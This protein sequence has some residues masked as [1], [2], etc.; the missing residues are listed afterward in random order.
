MI[1]ITEM[2]MYIIHPFI[3]SRAGCGCS[4]VS[5]LVFEKRSCG[6]RAWGQKVSE[7]REEKNGVNGLS[8]V[9]VSRMK[10]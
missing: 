6:C 8:D 10:T 4:P 9:V 3:Y 2:Q 1:F 5:Y 7:M